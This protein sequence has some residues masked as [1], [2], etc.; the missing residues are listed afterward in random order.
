LNSR[1]IGGKF[2]GESKLSIINNGKETEAFFIK[3]AAES[4]QLVVCTGR[5]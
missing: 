2:T 3:F 5:K 4:F 1:R